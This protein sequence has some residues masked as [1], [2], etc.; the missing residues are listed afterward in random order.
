MTCILKAEDTRGLPSFDIDVGSVS[1][2]PFGRTFSEGPTNGLP[3]GYPGS[4]P[5]S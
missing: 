4:V 1:P 2:S 5:V 3:D